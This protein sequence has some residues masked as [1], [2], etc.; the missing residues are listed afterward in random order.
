MSTSGREKTA[1]V[2]GANTGI[3]RVTAVELARRGMN[4]ILAGRSRE[5]TQPVIDEI[6]A[7]PRA[8]HVTFVPLNLADLASVRACAASIGERGVS[9]DLLVNNA[10]LAGGR[11]A[12][13]DGFEIHFGIN[14]L[15][16]F[17]LTNL[18]L[19]LIRQA[20]EARIVVV[21]SQAHYSPKDIDWEAVQNPTRTYLGFHEY[22][23]SKLCNVLFMKEL[24]RRIEGTGVR[25]YALHPG[26][27]ASDIW[28]RVP[29]PVRPLMTRFMITNEEGAQTTLHCATSHEAA[30]DNGLYYDRC[31]PKEP[32]PLANDRDL[33]AE[34]W[35][36]SEAWVA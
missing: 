11:G 10:G 3:G 5:R 25:T 21:A 8:P 4:L 22:S 7:L 20:S 19:D 27:V 28:R 1:V 9:V 33:Q 26:V 17:L 14:H 13:R 24:A 32:S 18:L 12:T 30:S 34:L 6:A 16:H 23:V 29:W 31:K 2:T 36:R 35:K 15:G